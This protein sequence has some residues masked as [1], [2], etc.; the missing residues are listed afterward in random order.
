[1][2]TNETAQKIQDLYFAN[3]AQISQAT[4]DE[5][6]ALIDKECEERVERVLNAMKPYTIKASD[7]IRIADLT[8]KQFVSIVNDESF[9]FDDEPAS[10]KTDKQ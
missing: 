2:K 9:W 5:T 8:H 1:M 6:I 10:T 4:W 3:G 7:D